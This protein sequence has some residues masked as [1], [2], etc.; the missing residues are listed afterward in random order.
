MSRHLIKCGQPKQ[1][2]SRTYMW[3]LR[4]PL[5]HFRASREVRWQRGNAVQAWNQFVQLREYLQHH[6]YSFVLHIHTFSTA[7]MFS[8][9]VSISVMKWWTVS[10]ISFAAADCCVAPPNST[11]PGTP[12]SRRRCSAARQFN[13]NVTT[14]VQITQYVDTLYCCINFLTSWWLKP[15]IACAVL[16]W[17]ISLLHSSVYLR[18]LA[19]AV[20]F[21]VLITSNSRSDP[22]FF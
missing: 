18:M 14:K 1:H 16:N 20:N 6:S 17:A 4:I 5:S 7:T 9:T 11:V 15:H 2:I 22:S 19:C 10:A 21:I 3:L 13:Y 12:I 8:L